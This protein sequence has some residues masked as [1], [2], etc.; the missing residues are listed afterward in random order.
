MCTLCYYRGRSGCVKDRQGLVLLGHLDLWK[1]PVLRRGRSPTFLERSS[2]LFGSCASF[3]LFECFG[4]RKQLKAGRK[5]KRLWQRSHNVGCRNATPLLAFLVAREISLRK[6]N[7]K[8]NVLCGA[9][10][11]GLDCLVETNQVQLEGLLNERLWKRFCENG[12]AFAGRTL[13][14]A[15]ATSLSKRMESHSEVQPIESKKCTHFELVGILG[16]NS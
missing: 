12:T 3:T 13:L 1:L 16:R 4:R 7:T 9:Y 15:S 2:L 11:G 8:E 14:L 10:Q 5:Y 6:K